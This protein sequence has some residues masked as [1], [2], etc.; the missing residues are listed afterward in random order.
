MRQSVS[1][2]HAAIRH[3]CRVAQDPGQQRW[4]Y[5][6]HLVTCMATF[7]KPLHVRWYPA[8]AHCVCLNGWHASPDVRS[9]SHA[10]G[11]MSMRAVSHIAVAKGLLAAAWQCRG[12]AAT[13][14]LCLTGLSATMPGRGR[15]LGLLRSGKS[16]V[17]CLNLYESMSSSRPSSKAANFWTSRACKG[18]RCSQ[19]QGYTRED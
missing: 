16:K 8:T 13:L 11:L 19:I 10:I 2:P 9:Q 14:L 1:Q 15:C 18:R 3:N 17:S 7:F 4:L 6:S 12:D 5:R